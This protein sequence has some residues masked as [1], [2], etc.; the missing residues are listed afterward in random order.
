MIH[1]SLLVANRGEYRYI[2]PE[3]R[4]KIFKAML[5]YIKN[6]D[7]TFFTIMV[8]KKYIDNLNV[9]INKLEKE[10]KDVLERNKEFFNKYNKKTFY[11]DGGQKDFKKILDNIL[12]KSITNYEIIKNFDKIEERLFQVVDFITYIDKIIF[13]RKNKIKLSNSERQFFTDEELKKIFKLMNKK[14]L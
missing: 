5:Q 11:Y 8:N 9:F 3:I 10:F 4:K 12:N 1:T 7:I 6:I 2:T 14:R 13:H